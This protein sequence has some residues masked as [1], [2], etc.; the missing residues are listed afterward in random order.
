MA[1]MLFANNCNTTLNGGITAVATSMVVTSAA[2]FPVPTGSQYFYC[3]LADAAT[4]TTIE[5]VKVTAISGTTFTI[6]RGQDGTTGTI[7]AS[8]AVVSLRLVRASLNDFPK[9]DETNTFTAD[10]AITGQL[11]TSAGLATTS[12]FTATPPADGLVMDYAT[13]FGRFS[14]F[15]GDGFQW[16]NAGVANTKLMELS[17]AGALT[18]TSTVTANGV[19]L[20]GNTGTVTSVAALTLGTTGTDLTSTVANGTTTPVITL[21]VPTASASNRGA[22][23]STDWSTFNSKQ[24]TLVSG[25]NIKTV[26]GVSLLGSGDVGTI[27]VGYG[28]TGLTTLASHYIPY[29]NGASAFSSSSNLQFD[30]TN[31]GVG[32]A[33][34][35]NANRT[36]LTLNNATW[37]GQYEL[38]VGA[39][40]KST[41][42]WST[43]GA[44]IFGTFVAEPLSFYANSVLTATLDTSGNL[45]VGTVTPDIFSSS[46]KVLSVYNASG[47]AQVQ[48]S[49]SSAGRI[50]FGIGTT[51]YGVIYQDS[52]NF[53]QIGTQTALPVVF[54]TN[55]AE[56]MR[57]SSTGI[58]TMNAYGAGAATFSAAGVISSVSDETWKIKD[59]APVNPDEMLQKLEPGYWFYNEEKAP[60][61]GEDRQL[62]F[63]AQNVNAA[64]G[65]E[66]APIPEEGKPWGYYD[67][68]VLAVTVMSLQNALKTIEEL[69]NKFDAY[70]ASHP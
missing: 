55:A 20:T 59:G 31:L 68:S 15:A 12:T 43:G 65:V 38:A 28:G 5:I 46:A 66:A 64:I 67:R 18:T 58:V 45:G 26:G 30:G 13:G 51:R 29:G 3:T 10:Q 14:A 6:V 54:S 19:L 42:F 33:A 32:G 8:G 37:G 44:T 61:F 52:T 25:T 1:N 56:R 47:V 9:L 57:I 34:N 40:V 36:T 17:S 41:W 24:A 22:L 16:Y 50:D 35:S 39:T 48:I 53:M 69:N 7:F 2:G 21:N 4:Q 70:V 23:S 63:Y 62:G 60:I 11:T 27:G 49:G